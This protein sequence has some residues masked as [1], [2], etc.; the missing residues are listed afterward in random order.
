LEPEPGRF[1]LLTTLCEGWAVC[2]GGALRF[3]SGDSIFVPASTGRIALECKGELLLA[4][5]GHS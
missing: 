3:R 4:T 2:V 1:R 5:P